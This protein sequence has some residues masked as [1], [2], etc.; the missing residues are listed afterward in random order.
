MVFLD[1]GDRGDRRPQA[2]DSSPVAQGCDRL[3]GTISQPAAYCLETGLRRA[4]IEEE[5]AA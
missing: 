4:G 2:P 5:V 1:L 3:V